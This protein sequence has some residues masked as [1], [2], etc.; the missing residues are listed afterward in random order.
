MFG[1]RL[2]DLRG[3]AQAYRGYYA[4]MKRF[5]KGEHALSAAR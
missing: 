5:T 2:F 1:R 4:E 3:Q